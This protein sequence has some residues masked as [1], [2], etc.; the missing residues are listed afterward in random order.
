MENYC[1]LTNASGK[2]RTIKLCIG[3]SIDMEQRHH[4]VVQLSSFLAIPVTKSLTLA[5]TTLSGSSHVLWD[6]LECLVTLWCGSL[7]TLDL[8]DSQTCLDLLQGGI[9]LGSSEIT[10]LGSLL[11]DLIQG[12]TDNGTLDLVATLRT[13]LG[14]SFSQTL[15]VQ[16]TPSLSP[17]QFGSLFTLQSQG[18]RLAGSQKDRLSVT[19][20]HEL[21]IARVDTVL[22][23]GTKFS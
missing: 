10:L 19:T 6:L 12:S 22:R 9:T 8:V 7:C 11:L 16:T 21:T 17:D 5:S 15:L 13:L 4:F 18:E 23:K 1:G 3:N 2:A 14:G 20:D